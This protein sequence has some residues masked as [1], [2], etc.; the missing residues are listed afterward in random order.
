MRLF[1][2]YTAKPVPVFAANAARISIAAGI[3]FASLLASLHVL[4]PEYDP[5]WRFI[6]EYALG[7][8]G[9]LMTLAFAALAVSLASAGLSL[10]PQVR[11][12]AAYVGLFVLAVAVTGIT[13]AA[14]FPTDPVTAAPGAATES[15]RL[16][17]LGASLDYTPVGALLLSLDLTRSQAW[18]PV[19][20]ALFVTAAITILAT[21]LFMALLPRDLVFGP[22]TYAGLAGRVLLLS[23]L[24]WIFVVGLHTLKLRKLQTQS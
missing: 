8:Y 18:R 5:T 10:L 21:I 23:Y 6:S 1:A 22:G 16:H 13:L 9:W 3:A 17:V 14:I 7:P 2:P 15:G 20:A 19:R 12:V 24:G 4:E 11:G